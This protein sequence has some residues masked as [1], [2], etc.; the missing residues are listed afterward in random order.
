MNRNRYK[1]KEDNACLSGA[2][3]GLLAGQL[4]KDLV[5]GLKKDPQRRFGKLR[6][7]CDLPKAG[8][9]ESALLQ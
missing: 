5:L 3:R 7:I 8:I 9:A 1:F 4:A 2:K 6:I